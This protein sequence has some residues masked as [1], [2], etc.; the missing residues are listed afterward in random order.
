MLKEELVANRQCATLSQYKSWWWQG[1]RN[2]RVCA[3]LY[4]NL[5]RHFDWIGTTETLSNETL[6]LLHQLLSMWKDDGGTSVN[7]KEFASYNVGKSHSIHG[8]NLFDSTLAFIRQHTCLDRALW[9][10][11]QRDY[12]MKQVMKQYT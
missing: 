6:P 10:H 8:E 4:S 9:E 7:E 12:P 11:V 5:L 3:E 1:V 2:P